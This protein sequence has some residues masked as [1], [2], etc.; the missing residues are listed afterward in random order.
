MGGF[1][2]YML[3]LFICLVVLIGWD[4]AYRRLPHWMTVPGI[5]YAAVLHKQLPATNMLN[6]LL[7]GATAFL[8][9][10]LIY[11]TGKLG[12][13]DVMLAALIGTAGGIQLGLLALA[14]G[15]LMAGIGALIAWRRGEQTIP[16]GAYLAVGATIFYLV[17]NIQS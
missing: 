12:F 8:L 4:V 5:V 16:Y 17:G 6:A 2:R 3:L 11:Q 9:F 13:G 15:M 14:T 1:L 7:G 10:L